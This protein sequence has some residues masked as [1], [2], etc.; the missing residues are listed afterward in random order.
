MKRRRTALKVVRV[1]NNLTQQQAADKI[2][3]SRNSYIPIEFGA[4]P[5]TMAFWSRVQ[6][7]FHI[8]DSEMWGLIKYDNM[9]DI[10]AETQ[11]P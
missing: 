8:P 3:V 7:A 10:N 11:H 2:G 1:K 6:K 4:R 9:E 5:G